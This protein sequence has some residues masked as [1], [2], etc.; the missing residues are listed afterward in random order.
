MMEFYKKEKVNPMAGCLPQVIQIPIFF[1]LYKVLYVS[2]ELRQ[3]PFYGWIRDMAAPDPTSWVNFFGLAHW[4]IPSQY[5]LNLGL[6]AVY[7]PPALHIGLWPFL[8]G[9]S[10]FL[11]QRLSPQPPDKTQARMF[12]FMPIF[13]TYLLSSMPSGLVIYWTWSNLI[14]IAQQAYI[15]RKDSAKR[16]AR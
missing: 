15:M 6:F 16:A 4:G 5:V 11:Q 13:F 1:A 12:M 3:A 7:L 8:M 10:M 14:S 2:I 9:L